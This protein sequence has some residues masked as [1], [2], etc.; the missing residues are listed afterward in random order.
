MAASVGDIDF[1]KLVHANPAAAQ[2]LMLTMQSLYDKGALTG[3]NLPQWLAERKVD[4][5][6]LIAALN[7]MTLEYPM[8]RVYVPVCKYLH[9]KM[10]PKSDPYL[11][12]PHEARLIMG[13]YLGLLGRKDDAK[14]LFLSV[15]E[16]WQKKGRSV[17]MYDVAE[18]LVF[19]QHRYRLGIWAWK[20]AADVL[21]PDARLYVCT[22]I[23]SACMWMKSQEEV[24]EELIP[25]AEQALAGG[26][27]APNWWSWAVPSLIWAYNYVGQPQNA[28]AVA[29]H[30][31]DKAKHLD[32]PPE[33]LVPSV[34]TQLAPAL[35]ATHHLDQAVAIL[36]SL[37][38]DGP[39]WAAEV[40]EAT[41]LATKDHPKLTRAELV[42]PQFHIMM[43]LS[44][45][46][47]STPKD[48]GKCTATVTGN[49]SFKITGCTSDVKCVKVQ[50]GEGRFRYSTVDYVVT[51]TTGPAAQQR[52]YTG[53][54]RMQTN[55]PAR[56]EIDEPL[57]VLVGE[58]GKRPV[59]LP[60]PPG[61]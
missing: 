52:L 46:V 8:K 36:Q 3:D 15:P 21:G 37:V 60:P 59:P 12:F 6:A 9:D 57:R 48:G 50:V 41:I 5:P 49:P 13:I 58:G 26:E 1:S 53:V 47:I 22:Q 40:V 32:M 56:P 23:E 29:R 30:W 54:V 31:L 42:P 55:D 4:Q 61:P 38:K 11:K 27:S 14:K 16:A 17:P 18:E 39:Q 45:Y 7:Q 28:I 51:V 35:V 43:P 33:D 10:G 44:F 25:W 20:R 24:R 2:T 34:D 19:S